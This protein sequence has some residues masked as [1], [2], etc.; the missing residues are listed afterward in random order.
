MK[1]YPK[2]RRLGHDDVQDI[3][4]AERLTIHEKM[5]GANFRFQSTE[6]VEGT[7]TDDPLVFGS[8]NNVYK[9]PKDI[10]K[11]FQ[12]A[13]D[14][15][16]ENIDLD[17]LELIRDIYGPVIFYG[18]AMHKHTFDYEWD[19]TPSFLG[20]DVWSVQYSKFIGW[21]IA[22]FM[23]ENLGLEPVPTVE[24]DTSDVNTD[25][26]IPESVYRDGVAEGVTI[27]D[28]ENQQFAKVRSDE[29]LGKFKQK[30]G[31]TAD[32]ERRD[33]PDTTKLA[34]NILAQDQ[35][36]EKQIHRYE[37]NGRTIGMEIME[38]LW[39]DVFD[40]IIEEEYATIFLG[41]WTIDTKDFRSHI[42]SHCAETLRNHMKRRAQN[43]DDRSESKLI[44]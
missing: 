21:D 13:I 17:E 33:P 20:F 25:I 39:R 35:W 3:L 23:F 22:E 11:N 19:E 34:N 26:E 6:D 30:G 32:G 4:N 15:V 40:D 31:Q 9:N 28:Y 10:D 27:K 29:F 36:V 24:Y 42:A 41:N 2:I 5:D 18:E 44:A 8:R 37:N 7:E 16:L 38:D 43:P 14:Y 12:H 1:K